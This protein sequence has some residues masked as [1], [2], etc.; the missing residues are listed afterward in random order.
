MSYDHI[1]PSIFTVLTSPSH[2]PGIAAI[3]FVIFPYRWMVAEHSFRPPY[4]HR[5][6][7]SEFMGLIDGQYDAKQAGFAPGGFSIHNAMIPHGPDKDSTKKAQD[8]TLE[9]FYFDNGLAFMLESNQVWSP[10]EW[11]MA[12]PELQRD[13]INCWQGMNPGK[14]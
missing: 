12:Q 9:P 6:I 3:D 5:N 10:S 11:A 13:Y 2:S 14:L 7:M 4:F 8:E 1:D